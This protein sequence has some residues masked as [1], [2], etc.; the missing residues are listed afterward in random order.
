MKKIVRLSLPEKCRI[1]AVSDIHTNREL[2][3][4]M[5]ESV[6]YNPDED[7]LVIVGD[8]LEHWN[9]N[10]NTL[11][12]VKNLCENSDKAI[13]LLGNNDIRCVKMAFDYDY[14]KFRKNFVY[15]RNGNENCFMQMAHNVGFTE[16]TEENFTS[17]RKAVCDKY[18]DYL[19]FIKNLPVCLETEKYVFV[20]AGVENRPDWENTSDKFAITVPWFMRKENPTGKWLVVGHY[21]TYNY[22]RAN[23]TNL[24]L[25]DEKKKMICID[26]GLGIKTACQMNFLIIHKD[27]ENYTHEIKWK[28]PYPERYVEKDFSCSLTPQYVDW[29]NQDIEILSEKCGLLK[30]HDKVRNVCGYI[31]KRSA[32]KKDGRITVYQT[33]S[34]FPEVKKGE[35]VNVCSEDNGLLLVITQNGKVGWIP[36]EN[37]D[38]N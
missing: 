15:N 14:V 28:S 34:S 9:D 30:V 7:Y 3:D 24:P 29:S 19:S 21:P 4:K 25:V 27:G 6:K 1:I 36:A 32:Y 2:F 26:G 8:F 35:W 38:L 37:I 16:C 5:L 23:A 13:C 12:Y 17:M 33:L 20:H 11:E 31:P 22:K 18:G 10:L